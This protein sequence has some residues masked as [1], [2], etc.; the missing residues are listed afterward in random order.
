MFLRWKICDIS[1]IP[2]VK[3]S[4]L[5]NKAI[6]YIL[7]IHYQNK[8]HI[9]LL[10]EKRPELTYP[11]PRFLLIGSFGLTVCNCILQFFCVHISYMFKTFLQYWLQ[12]HSVGINKE[13]M[14]AWSFPLCRP[15]K[16][17]NRREKK[18][19]IVPPP[20]P[21]PP[22]YVIFICFDSSDIGERGLS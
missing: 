8:A 20:P 17:A 14:Y 5:K 10:D 13:I 22:P 16:I 4:Y 6:H 3:L 7:Y 18:R 21:P 11:V 1:S 2:N 15:G 19:L 12:V 9:Y